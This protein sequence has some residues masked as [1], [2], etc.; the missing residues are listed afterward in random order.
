[1]E[2]NSVN[3]VIVG[4]VCRANTTTS[5]TSISLIIKMKITSIANNKSEPDN[6]RA[7]ENPSGYATRLCTLLVLVI[8]SRPAHNAN[9]FFS[10]RS[11]G[12]RMERSIGLLSMV[13][14]SV[15]CGTNRA[16]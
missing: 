1:M 5:T 14:M 4:P 12:K 3:I 11:H 13:R 9:G 10:L 8:Q 16:I 2:H 7:H 15:L 6:F